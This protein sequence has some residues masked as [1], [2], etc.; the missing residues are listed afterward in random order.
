MLKL[1]VFFFFFFFITGIQRSR[2]P[3]DFPLPIDPRSIKKKKIKLEQLKI[4]K[5]FDLDVFSISN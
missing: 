1:I 2:Y 4:V 3:R 5:D